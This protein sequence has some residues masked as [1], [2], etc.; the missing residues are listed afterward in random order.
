M[1]SDER[2]LQ[3]LQEFETTVNQSGLARSTSGNQI[4]TAL[5]FI[6]AGEFEDATK[7]IGE[8]TGNSPTAAF[9]LQGVVAGKRQELKQSEA[10]FLA[11]VDA[12][13]PAFD[14]LCLNGD[15]ARHFGHYETAIKSFDRA[16]E[17]APHAS[18][19]H[20]RRGKTYSEA[21]DVSAAI[22]DLLRATLLQPNF[23]DAHIALGDEYR[24]AN[25]T[26]A[27]AKCYEAALKLDPQNA[28]ARTG[29]DL[30]LALV[31]P[32]WHSAMLNDE[33]RNRAFDTAIAAAVT[34]D[35]M[36]LDIGTGTGLLAM[37]AARAGAKKVLGCESIGMLAKTAKEIVNRNGFD[38]RISIVH[39]R[40]Q[41][42][43]LGEDLDAPADIL[44]AELVDVGLLGENILPIVT[45]TLNRLCKPGATIIP[46]GASIFAAPIESEELARER[47]VSQASGFEI[48]PFNSLR[49]N[50]Y[51]Q[52]NLSKYD[53]R[54]LSNPVEVFTFDF[55]CPE[56]KTRQTEIRLVPHTD[57]LAHGIAFWF[58]LHLNAEISISTSPSEAP[59]HWHQAVY[60]QSEPLE[61]KQNEPVR[62]IANHNQSKISFTLES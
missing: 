10:K 20:L 25:M 21:G 34:P 44:I 18:H 48:S 14:V 47:Q 53:W 35:S 45:D 28:A 2:F 50:I 42:L 46:C 16:I 56:P 37:M 5:K 58:D 61:L 33:L 17:V 19:A 55:S 54:L 11:A 59:T 27:A 9:V 51:L 22:D 43:S 31:L 49:P 41:D 57:G 6:R 4:L 26:D 36:V 39:K 23:V 1:K 13:E 3:L 62:L 29:L 32:Q 8:T 15:F 60:T 12:P 38:D 30:T 24:S 40:S 7:A 52:T